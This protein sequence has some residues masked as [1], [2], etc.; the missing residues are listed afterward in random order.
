[1]YSSVLIHKFNIFHEM[2]YSS[3]GRMQCY[4]ETEPHF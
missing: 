3:I 4:F 2:E 1:M